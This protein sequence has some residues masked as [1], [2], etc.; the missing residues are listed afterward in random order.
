MTGL[1]KDNSK[2]S[3]AKQESQNSLQQKRNTAKTNQDDATEKASVRDE[4]QQAVTPEQIN[5]KDPPV[6]QSQDELRLNTTSPLEAPVDTA[7]YT[8]EIKAAFA[9]EGGVIHEVD[10][11]NQPDDRSEGQRVSLLRPDQKGVHHIVKSQ[12]TDDVGATKENF[13]TDQRIREGDMVS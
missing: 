9:D 7:L 10:E 12:G 1:K 8:Q 13:L 11:E 6:T 3:L 5:V 4:N 2:G